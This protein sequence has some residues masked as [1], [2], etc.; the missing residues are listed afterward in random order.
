MAQIVTEDF[1][2]SLRSSPTGKRKYGTLFD[3]LYNSLETSENPLD[4][5]IQ[6]ISEFHG[7]WTG[8]SVELADLSTF[9]ASKIKT[10]ILKTNAMSQISSALNVTN[11]VKNM[12]PS[13]VGKIS[14]QTCAI[15]PTPLLREFINKAQKL[16]PSINMY[17]QMHIGTFPYFQ[18]ISEDVGQFASIVMNKSSID[19]MNWPAQNGVN[20]LDTNSRMSKNTSMKM[21]SNIFN[22]MD[23]ASNMLNAL[24]LRAMPKHN[25]MSFLHPQYSK[26]APV[27]HGHN[28]T[29]DV[30]NAARN[31]ESIGSCMGAVINLSQDTL[32]LVNKFFNVKEMIKY[33]IEGFEI[34]M[35]EGPQGEAITYVVDNSGRPLYD[36]D[37]PNDTTDPTND[38]VVGSKPEFKDEQQ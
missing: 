21:P 16:H 35:N 36:N 33:E 10:P 32:R 15:M 14:S 30:F 7:P 3:E 6:M 12:V 23:N 2:K 37:E 8:G 34:S 19:P 11:A 29:M 20:C 28:F 4:R 38:L 26:E 24:S 22:L 1:R 13:A 25:S 31:I 9:I 18:Q 17:I 27:A 5:A